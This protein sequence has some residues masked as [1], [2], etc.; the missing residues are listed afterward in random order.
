VPVKTGSSVRIKGYWQT[1]KE[2]ILQTK[3]GTKHRKQLGKSTAFEKSRRENEAGNQ[4]SPRK[5]SSRHVERPR[6]GEENH[7]LK[8]RVSYKRGRREDSASFTNVEKAS[9]KGGLSQLEGAEESGRGGG[10]GDESSRL[11]SQ[12]LRQLSR[13]KTRIGPAVNSQK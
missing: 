10:G 4:L 5:S 7:R 13:Q 9:R 6:R 11:R 2:G 8:R 12:H 1:G 3:G